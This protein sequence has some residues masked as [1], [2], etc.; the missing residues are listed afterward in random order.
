MTKNFRWCVE[1]NGR[2]STS[3]DRSS[4]VFGPVGSAK[5]YSYS[6]GGQLNTGGANDITGVANPMLKAEDGWPNC[7]VVAAVTLS[8]AHKKAPGE[9]DVLG[10]RRTTRSFFR[11]PVDCRST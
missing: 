7:D 11:E 6:Q 10:G 4:H 3:R 5:L 9:Y 8:S 2:I 1:R